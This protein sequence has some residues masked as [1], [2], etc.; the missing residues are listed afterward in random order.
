MRGAARQLRP[1]YRGKELLALETGTPGAGREARAGSAECGGRVWRSPQRRAGPGRGCRGKG[2]GLG[3]WLRGAGAPGALWSGPGKR[4]GA[5]GG[6]R[7]AGQG[8]TKGG[9]RWGGPGAWPTGSRWAGTGALLEEEQ[10]RGGGLRALTGLPPPGPR[11]T[12]RPFGW[13]PPAPRA[14]F[15]VQGH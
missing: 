6:G 8:G 9:D 15:G 4:P 14:L 2:Q 10:Q 11:R 12:V 1:G 5:R 3:A 13:M 7:E